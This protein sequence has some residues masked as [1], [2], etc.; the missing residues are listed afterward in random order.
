MGV[1][2]QELEPLT[3]IWDKGVATER[4]LE[5]RTST[6][7]SVVVTGGELEPP[8]PV[9]DKGVPTDWVLNSRSPSLDKIEAPL[10]R[11]EPLTSTG[12]ECSGCRPG[13]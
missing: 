11:L 13:T 12:G 1:T 5:P 6:L 7:D 10:G 2:G 8:T 9:L 3:S 4:G